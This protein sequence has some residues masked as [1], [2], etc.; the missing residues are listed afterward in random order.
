MNF[1]TVLKFAH[2]DSQKVT[3]TL[4]FTCTF[5]GHSHDL[6]EWEFRTNFTR[7][8]HKFSIKLTFMSHMSPICLSLFPLCNRAF[9]LEM[10]Q[11]LSRLGSVPDPAADMH[12][13]Y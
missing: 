9:F 6:D 12:P 5:T 8:S 2:I 3:F 11:H 10:L 1:G 4:A 13:H 7:V